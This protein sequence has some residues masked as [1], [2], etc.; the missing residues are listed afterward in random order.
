MSIYS[1]LRVKILSE[2]CDLSDLEAVDI[3][4][5]FLY[6]MKT[7][8]ARKLKKNKTSENYNVLRGIRDFVFIK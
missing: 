7:K 2:W 6:Q 5:S 3:S 4:D 8:Q 1:Y